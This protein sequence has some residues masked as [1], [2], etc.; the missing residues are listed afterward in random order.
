MHFRHRGAARLRDLELVAVGPASGSWCGVS[1]IRAA[2]L[3]PHTTDTSCGWLRR[4]DRLGRRM[5]VLYG[6][7]ARELRM[8]CFTH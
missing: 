3:P 8:K 1:V 5:L 4:A 2:S 6:G 7:V